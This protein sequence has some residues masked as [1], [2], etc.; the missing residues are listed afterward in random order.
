MNDFFYVIWAAGAL[1]LAGGALYGYRMNWRKSLIYALVWA[2][3]FT[4]ATLF[5]NAVNV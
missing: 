1:A 4:V 2:C 5:I 3:L